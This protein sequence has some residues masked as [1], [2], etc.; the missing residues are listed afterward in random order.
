MTKLLFYEISLK[1]RLW[2]L[3]PHHPRANELTTMVSTVSPR[4]SLFERLVQYEF[5]EDIHLSHKWIGT[6]LCRTKCRELLDR[7]RI[8]KM[9]CNIAESEIQ[10]LQI[11][12]MQMSSLISPDYQNQAVLGQLANVN[13]MANIYIGLSISSVELQ[14]CYPKRL[15]ETGLYCPRSGNA[16]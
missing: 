1:I 14:H 5:R 13:C 10:V 9:L 12:K 4:T 16:C 8:V 6:W 2:E 3:L 15:A 7:T 11:Q